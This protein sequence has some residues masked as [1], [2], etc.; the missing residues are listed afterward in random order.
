MVYKNL[1]IVIR[2]SLNN[3]LYKLVDGL[4]CSYLFFKDVGVIML[5]FLKICYNELW[6]KK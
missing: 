3:N 1:C 4:I 6:E 5:V 2:I